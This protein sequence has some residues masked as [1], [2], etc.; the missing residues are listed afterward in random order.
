MSLLILI[1]AVAAN[2]ILSFFVYKR[3]P[4]SATNVIYILLNT[5]ISI[6]LIVNYLSINTTGSSQTLLLTR[7]SVFFA[8]PMSS[9]FLLF[10][11]TLP[12]SQLKISH[13]WLYSIVFITVIIMCLNM[14]SLTFKN[15][16]TADDGSLVPVVGPGIIPF[17]IF[18][19]FFS[20]KAIY[21]LL[22]KSLNSVGKERLQYRFVMLGILFML[23]LIISTILIPVIF[24]QDSSFVAL[25][26]VYSL[27]F[28]GMTAYAI[29][30]YRLMDI[31]LVL[32]RSII[33]GSLVVFVSSS[34]VFLTYF[35][36]VYFED[37][38]ISR[39][40][41]VGVISLMI[42]VIIDPLKA[43]I[44][45]VT[46][47][48]FYRN[49]IDYTLASKE[50]T[51]IVNSEIDFISLLKKFTK[52]LQATFR[53]DSVGVL[54]A[55]DDKTFFIPDELSSD[56]LKGSFQSFKLFGYL[57]KNKHVLLKDDIQDL[58]MEDITDNKRKKYNQISDEINKLNAE[59]F[60]PVFNK[61]GNNIEA[62]LVLSNKLSGEPFSTQD[63]SLLEVLS[64]QLSSAIIKSKLYQEAQ[65]FNQK[66]E[67]EVEKQTKELRTANE[68][69]TE[70][71]Q[72]KSEFMSIASHQ[73]RTP[74]AGIN[75]YLSMMEDGDFGRLTK[76]QQPIIHDVAQ[77][78]QRLIRM[79]NVFLNVTRIEAGRFVMNYTKQPFGEVMMDIYKTLKPTA[80]AKGVKLTIDEKG[81]NAL[82]TIDVDMDKIKDVI[83]NLTDNAIKYSPEG[84]VH[85]SAEANSRTVH[86][87][88]KDSG[89]GIPK[90]EVDNLFDKF[91]RGS[92]IARVEP[93]G[94]GLGLFIARKIVEGHG[95]KIWAASEG[96][97]K[98]STFQFKIPIKADKEAKKKTEE[99]K[100][101]AKK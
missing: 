30:K 50:L 36:S 65:E 56:N 95:G 43:T 72:A 2:L 5:V 88:I 59:A 74:L 3:N 57:K 23:G 48:F 6:W 83:I 41:F 70:L 67:R 34:F 60:V 75:G 53:L 58:L 19:T 14:T 27:A 31:R 94:S 97:G 21:T 68:K 12:S 64:L 55:V 69:L 39:T 11:Q 35:G 98:G 47:A 92:G 40:I 66:L 42:V 87:M 22:K 89:V 49:A 33:Y 8:M 15:V 96:E 51:D 71:D 10:S 13:T 86:V 9:L 26:P 45:R 32:V 63:L 20:L 82:P 84:H 25:A 62:I 85:M 101:R 37:N 46:D 99:F 80:D 81:V 91:V 79:V 73:L 93:N 38:A 16:M 52:A 29:I 4:K 61:K 7:L 78:T 17:S 54:L 90:E 100:K 18:S 76:A 77:A 24:V 1:G 44:A 28:L